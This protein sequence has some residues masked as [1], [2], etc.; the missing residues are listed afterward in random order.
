MR[1]GYRD[2]WI[3][4]KGWSLYMSI[5]IPIDERAKSEKNTNIQLVGEMHRLKQVLELTVGDR[6]LFEHVAGNISTNNARNGLTA[7]KAGYRCS[8]KLECVLDS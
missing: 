3:N 5:I 1:G 7:F 8:E 2:V 4:A 6:M